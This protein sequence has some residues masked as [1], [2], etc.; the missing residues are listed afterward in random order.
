MIAGKGQLIWKRLFGVI[1]ST[2]I[3]VRISAL[4]FFVASLKLFVA[5]LGLSK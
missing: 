2:K 5:S 4:N 1:V 3:I